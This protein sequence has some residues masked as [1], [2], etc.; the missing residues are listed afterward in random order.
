MEE[1]EKTNTWTLP[2]SRKTVK[3]EGDSDTNCSM[4]TWNGLQRLGKKIRRAGNQ[5]NK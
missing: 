4:C 3:H 5:G 2:E 1:S